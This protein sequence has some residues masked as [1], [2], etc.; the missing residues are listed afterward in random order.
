[1]LPFEILVLGDGKIV[2]EPDR[3]NEDEERIAAACIASEATKRKIKRVA[4]NYFRN[5]V[6]F[7]EMDTSVFKA[8]FGAELDIIHQERLA[9]ESLTLEQ[10][11]TKYPQETA[12]VIAQIMLNRY[13]W[14]P[15]LPEKR[16]YILGTKN[17]YLHPAKESL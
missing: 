8:H 16:V 12:D 3:L 9:D 13:S 7:S 2:N 17:Y 14:R 5:R 4:D 1:M 6:D 10:L 11:T 15:F